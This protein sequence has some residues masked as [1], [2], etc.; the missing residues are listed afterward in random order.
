MSI[1]EDIEAIIRDTQIFHAM[2][3]TDG[4][5]G[6]IAALRKLDPGTVFLDE[7]EKLF[8][9]LDPETSLGA[10]ALSAQREVAV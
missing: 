7:H 6:F 5:I 10:F 8:E 1:E 4:M 9:L 3:D 2:S